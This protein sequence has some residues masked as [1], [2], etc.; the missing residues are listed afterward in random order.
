MQFS[1]VNWSNRDLV[2]LLESIRLFDVCKCR[3]AICS[4]PDRFLRVGPSLPLT[5]G[6]IPFLCHHHTFFITAIVLDVPSF[7]TL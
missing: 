6:I 3:N 4:L 5:S 1:G 2:K 7:Q